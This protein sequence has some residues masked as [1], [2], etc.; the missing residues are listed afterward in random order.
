[1]AVSANKAAVIAYVACAAAVTAAL[2]LS[3]GALNE[4]DVLLAGSGVLIISTLC[5]AFV[6]ELF[7]KTS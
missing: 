7:R 5:A 1:M 2:A 3:G 6:H 4:T